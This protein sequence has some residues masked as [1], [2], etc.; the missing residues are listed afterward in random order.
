MNNEKFYKMKRVNELDPYG[1]ENWDDDGILKYDIEN[2]DANYP[3]QKIL[4]L[5]LEDLECRVNIDNIFDFISYNRYNFNQIRRGQLPISFNNFQDANNFLDILNRY[6]KSQYMKIEVC[7][8]EGHVIEL[9]K[10]YGII[11]SHYRVDERA[12]ITIIFD[13]CERI[14]M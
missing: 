10:F 9:M 2:F 3:N 14:F 4:I 12:N 11:L 6:N 5:K 13:Y 7:D 8:V 1:E